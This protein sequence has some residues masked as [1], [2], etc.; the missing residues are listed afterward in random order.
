MQLYKAVC[1]AC[2][3][4]TSD[5]EDVLE[6]YQAIYDKTVEMQGDKKK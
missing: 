2:G 3:I 1:K 4:D 5:M 6:D